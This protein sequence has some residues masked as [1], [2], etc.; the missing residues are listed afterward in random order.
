MNDKFDY[1]TELMASIDVGTGNTTQYLSIKVWDKNTSKVIDNL[2]N[3]FDRI[4]VGKTFQSKYNAYVCYDYEP[5]CIDGFII[6]YK[7]ADKCTNY[8]TDLLKFIEFLAIERLNRFINLEKQSE[9]SI[10]LK[11]KEGK[12]IKKIQEV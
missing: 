10:N 5:F 12:L 7:V 6:Q 9:L 4:E 3:E 8:K 11:S 2:L 1:K